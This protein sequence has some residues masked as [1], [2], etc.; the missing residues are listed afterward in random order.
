[1]GSLEPL[2]GVADLK[3]LEILHLKLGVCENLENLDTF[4]N[5]D[6]MTSLRTLEIE[7]SRSGKLKSIEPLKK[8]TK[9]HNL[10]NLHI[11]L[12]QMTALQSVSAFDDE[13]DQNGCKSFGLAKRN[14]PSLRSLKIYLTGCI[15]LESEKNLKILKNCIQTFTNV[16]IEIH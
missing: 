12:T 3:D 5:F 7:I 6:K 9:L 14:L 2:A 4:E 16:D 10:E 13:W 15:A 8:I 1:M 11:F